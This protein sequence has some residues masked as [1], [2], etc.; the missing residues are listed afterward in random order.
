MTD[1]VEEAV[2]HLQKQVLSIFI[3]IL[4]L[5]IFGFHVILDVED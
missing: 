5:Q 4:Q 1:P 3:Y 2:E